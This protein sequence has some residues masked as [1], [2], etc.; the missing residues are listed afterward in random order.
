MSD[1]AL[2][3]PYVLFF[4]V[5]AYAIRLKANE[6]KAKVKTQPKTVTRRVIPLC[7]LEHFP[8]AKWDKFNNTRILTVPMAGETIGFDLDG[9]IAYQYTKLREKVWEEWSM[10]D[11]CSFCEQ[12]PKQQVQSGGKQPQASQQQPQLKQGQVKQQLSDT[13]CDDFAMNNERFTKDE[14]DNKYAL[15]HGWHWEGSGDDWYPRRNKQKQP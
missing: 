13:Q 14:K 6:R 9:H 15:P 4:I 8:G 7:V 1:I 5:V 11:F 2:V 10:D 12:A 3:L